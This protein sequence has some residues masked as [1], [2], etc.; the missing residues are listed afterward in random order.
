M[1]KRTLW[2]RI[3]GGPWTAEYGYQCGIQWAS[4]HN[5]SEIAY[6]VRNASPTTEK[7]ADYFRG[8]DL[9]I[10]EEFYKRTNYGMIIRADGSTAFESGLTFQLEQSPS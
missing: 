10:R 5:V 1:I 8:F 3:L 4:H 7:R 6:R 9:A 2:D